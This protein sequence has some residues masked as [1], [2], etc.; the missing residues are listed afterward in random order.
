MEI[1]LKKNN[2]Y[3]N[4]VKNELVSVCDCDCAEK[5]CFHVHN[6]YYKL[7]NGKIVNSFRCH[8]REGGRCKG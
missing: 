4:Y 8:T 5:K 7:S 1:K 2:K 3:K 6:Y